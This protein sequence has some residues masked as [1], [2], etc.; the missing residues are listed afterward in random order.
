VRLRDRADDRQAEPDTAT[1]TG[2][3]STAEAIE[4]PT[5]QFLAEAVAAI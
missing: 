5:R 1:S 4:R 3:V 2:D